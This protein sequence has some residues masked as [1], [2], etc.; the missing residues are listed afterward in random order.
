MEECSS[1]GINVS[2][3]SGC[4]EGGGVPCPVVGFPAGG[5]DRLRSPK[6]TA[7]APNVEAFSRIFSRFS[8]SLNH[9]LSTAKTAIL[10]YGRVGARSRISIWLFWGVKVSF[11]NMRTST[12]AQPGRM[13]LNNSRG[14]KLIAWGRRGLTRRQNSEPSHIPKAVKEPLVPITASLKSA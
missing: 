10:T 2:L 3:S 1:S 5:G 7:S 12:L 13:T 14:K 6:T 11:D 9:Q 8:S 4:N